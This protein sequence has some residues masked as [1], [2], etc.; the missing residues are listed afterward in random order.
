MDKRTDNE[1]IDGVGRKK[2]KHI[3]GVESEDRE[4]NKEEAVNRGR[5][6]RQE[7]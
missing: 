1:Q 2:R 3:D 5:N 4:E 7:I 6:V